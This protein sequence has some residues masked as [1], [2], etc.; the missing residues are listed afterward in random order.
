MNINGLITAS[1]ATQSVFKR[2][3]ALSESDR[4]LVVAQAKKE[5]KPKAKPGKKSPP[6]EKPGGDLSG[7]VDGLVKEIEVIKSDGKV[8][9]SEVVGLID[10]MMQ[11]VDVLINA[12]PPRKKRTPPE[13]DDMAE[14][15]AADY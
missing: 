14:R 6:K 8:E 15:I 13:E 9:E 1:V 4:E 11:M 12:K 2:L 5:S 10:R 3:A 7:I